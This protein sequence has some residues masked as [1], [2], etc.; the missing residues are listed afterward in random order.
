MFVYNIQRIDVK[1][2]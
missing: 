2:L 1:S